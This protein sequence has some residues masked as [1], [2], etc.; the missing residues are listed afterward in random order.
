VDLGPG[1]RA[2]GQE[3]GGEEGG[4]GE[5]FHFAACRKCGLEKQEEAPDRG[6]FVLDLRMTEV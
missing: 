3:G 6:C 4:E 5:G 1:G 2:G